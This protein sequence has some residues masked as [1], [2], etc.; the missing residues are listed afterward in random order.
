MRHTQMLPSGN[1][2]LLYQT[3]SP[4]SHFFRNQEDGHIPAVPLPFAYSSQNMPFR[5]LPSQYPAAVT[6]GTCRSLAAHASACVRFGAPLRS[7]VP[8]ASS[9]P[10]SASRAAACPSYTDTC[11]IC[12]SGALSVKLPRMYSLHHRFSIS[13]KTAVLPFSICLQ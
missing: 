4:S 2:R 9:Q 1:I 7:H 13:V 8:S 6:G 10:L 12:R 5:V 11:E 3:K